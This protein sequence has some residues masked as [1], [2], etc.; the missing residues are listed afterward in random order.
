MRRL[1][2]LDFCS[3][4]EPESAT[5]TGVGS[6]DNPAAM[7]ACSNA[8]AA[9]AA[10]AAADDED[11]AENEVCCCCD[12]DEEDAA[13]NEDEAATD[14]RLTESMVGG[15]LTLFRRRIAGESKESDSGSELYP[16]PDS[17]ERSRA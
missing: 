5:R 8:A 11:D 17:E 15:L 16:P 2:L 10:A 6:L 13:E 1:F 7:A 3:F 4:V 12:E 9:A 14:I